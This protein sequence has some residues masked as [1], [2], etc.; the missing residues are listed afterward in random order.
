MTYTSSDVCRKCG[1]DITDVFGVRKK[2]TSELVRTLVDKAAKAGV[3]YL[4]F[5][6]E[7]G[8][9]IAE[10]REPWREVFADGQIRWSYELR[11]YLLEAT[12]IKFPKGTKKATGRFRHRIGGREV[13]LRT[14]VG[15]QSVR[16]NLPHAG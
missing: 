9:M 5:G 4:K 8:R 1:A 10:F 12:G 11:P 13:F 2:R 7:H 16:I 15:P 14:I 6:L 3:K